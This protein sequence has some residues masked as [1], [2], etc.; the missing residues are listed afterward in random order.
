MERQNIT[1]NQQNNTIIRKIGAIIAFSAFMA[2]FSGI[3]IALMVV[4]MYWAFQLWFSVGWWATTLCWLG[5]MA[6]Y[7]V[8]LSFG[9][10]LLRGNE[11]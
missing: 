11:E 6:L 10:E 1:M 4:G 8:A 9:L 3:A 5:L 2:I 7:V